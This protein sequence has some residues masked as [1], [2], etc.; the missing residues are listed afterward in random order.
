MYNTLLYAE[1]EH[2]VLL[3]FFCYFYELTNPNLYTFILDEGKEQQQQ[4]QP[5]IKLRFF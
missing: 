4:Q 1:F 3:I 2:L 5:E